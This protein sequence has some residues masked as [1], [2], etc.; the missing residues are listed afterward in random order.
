MLEIKTSF[1][2][3][4]KVSENHK[5][6]VDGHEKR[7]NQLKKSDKLPLPYKIE[8]KP[9]VLKEINLLDYLN[10]KGFMVRNAKRILEKEFGRRKLFEI[11]KKFG[12]RRRTFDNYNRRDS[13]PADFILSLGKNILGSILGKGEIGYNRDKISLPIKINLSDKLLEIIGLFIAEGY[14][15]SNNRLNQVYIASMD[16]ELRRF[17]ASFMKKE[18]G[19]VPTERKTD[20]VTFS[21]KILYLLFTKILGCGHDAYEKR[22]PSMFLNL[23]LEKLACVLRGYF[24]G[25][26]SAEKMRKK[27]SCDSVSEGLLCDL[28]FCLARFGIFAKRYE[29][30]KEPGERIKMFYIRKKRKIPK[31]K[32]TKIIIG[33]DFVDKFRQIG[34]L[35]KRKNS[36][37]EGYKKIKPLGMRIDYDENFV[38]DPIISIKSAGESESYCL[39]VESKE[40]SIFANS[41][42]SKQCDGDEAAAIML[43]DMLIN[44]SRKFLPAHRGGTQDAPLVLNTYIRAGDVDDQILDFETSLYPLE[45]YEMA[46]QGK[47]STEVKCVESVKK[48]LKEGKNPFVGVAFTHGTGDFNKCVVNSAYKSIPTMQ[49]K[50]DKQMELDRKIR[51]VDARDVERLII[52]RHFI[53]DT[54][55]NLRKFSQQSFRCVACN[56]IYRRTPLAGKCLKCGGRLIFTI[57]EGSI[58]KYME[59]ALQLARTYSVSP[60][61]LESLELTQMYIQSIFGKEK[62]KQEGLKKWFG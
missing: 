17:I 5:F 10:G 52:E 15:R 21:S 57:S 4:I 51:A 59:S 42:L 1:G 40:H 26:G 6:I 8:V 38:Y 56:E 46:E 14:A 39:N 43:T 11:A 3:K 34:F 32:I 30:E 47:H 61:L 35:S 55:G 7:A 49:E 23:P 36:I 20:R 13:Y 60:Y 12:I 28:E 48:R 29:Y 45:F 50:V 31:F 19:L 62:E 27:V 33:S 37:L 2:K 58:L 54:R 25:D 53:R 24:E 18:L 22:I 44:F 41:I 16:N 9:R